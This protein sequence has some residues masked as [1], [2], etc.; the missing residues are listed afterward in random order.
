MVDGGRAIVVEIGEDSIFVL[1][2]SEGSL[3]GSVKVEFKSP[4]EIFH[5]INRKKLEM[6]INKD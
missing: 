4:E 2:I 3:R 6:R 5:I 1:Q